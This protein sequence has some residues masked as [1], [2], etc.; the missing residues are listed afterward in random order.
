MAIQCFD[1]VHAITNKDNQQYTAYHGVCFNNGHYIT[2]DFSHGRTS[3]IF[4]ACGWGILDVDMSRIPCVAKRSKLG[5][6]INIYTKNFGHQFY[7][8]AEKEKNLPVNEIL[9]DLSNDSI[10]KLFSLISDFEFI[11]CDSPGITERISLIKNSHL[12]Y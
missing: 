10:R 12:N 9:A 6:L 2:H 1:T 7:C 11:N 3:Q 8:L 5:L 4:L